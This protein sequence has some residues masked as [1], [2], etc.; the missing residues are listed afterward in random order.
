MEKPP[1]QSAD[2]HGAPDAA[3][4]ARVDA[5]HR[6]ARRGDTTTPDQPPQPAP[7]RSAESERPRARRRISRRTLT[8]GSIG[9]IVS[10][11]VLATV[12]VH[13]LQPAATPTTR[14][15]PAPHAAQIAPL[16][17]G[18]NCPVD[19]AWSPDG[20]HIALLGYQDH[21]PDILNGSGVTVTYTSGL[22]LIYIEPCVGLLIYL[23]YALIRP[24]KF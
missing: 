18:L 2:A 12:V 20:S 4:D 22:L 9:V 8:I 24:E 17:D 13:N 14:Q 23:V 15:K 21:C 1:E 16:A 5:L 3:R 6:L 10:V 7:P 19:I 11:A